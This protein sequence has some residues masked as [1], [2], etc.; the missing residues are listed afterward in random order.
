MC[1]WSDRWL[2]PSQPQ[3]TMWTCRQPNG[4][5]TSR[6][7]PQSAHIK[8]NI[9]KSC[10]LPQIR[11]CHTPP[12]RYFPPNYKISNPLLM[13]AP[14]ASDSA[15]N[16]D[17]S[18][19]DLLGGSNTLPTWL[20]A[21]RFLQPDFDPELTVLDLRRFVSCLLFPS[22]VSSLPLPVFHLLTRSCPL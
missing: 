20:D 18:L 1:C 13:T 10:C 8:Q 6:S 22:F 4:W 17:P 5:Q 14:E 11:T 19:R 2:M 3:G 16:N 9:L 12:S 21:E 7:T 15:K